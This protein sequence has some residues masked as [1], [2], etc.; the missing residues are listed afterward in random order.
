M[1]EEIEVRL[2]DAVQAYVDRA[3]ARYASQFPTEYV[4]EARFLRDKLTRLA[5]NILD[6]ETVLSLYVVTGWFRQNRVGRRLA[7][8]VL[9]RNRA[10][11]PGESVETALIRW[12]GPCW[13]ASPYKEYHNGLPLLQTQR[14]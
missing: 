13:A 8:F 9:K 6:R 5:Y 7:E 10:L 1:L 14:G 12:L 3:V 4:A 2:P 11:R